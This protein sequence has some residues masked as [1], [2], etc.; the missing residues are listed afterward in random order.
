MSLYK[1]EELDELAQRRAR[2]EYLLG[3]NDTH[4][5]DYMT[6]DELHI[7]LLAEGGVYEQDGEYLFSE[8]DVGQEG[9]AYA[10][11]EWIG[12]VQ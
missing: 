2:D 1:Y 3:W 7:I 4:P 6:D 8:S 10:D 9:D 11:S 5:D 12:G